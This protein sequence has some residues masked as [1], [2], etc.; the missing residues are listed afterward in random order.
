RRQRVG[1]RARGHRDGAPDDG[2]GHVTSPSAP[3]HRGRELALRV[4]YQADVLNETRTVALAQI[5]EE[6]NPADPDDLAALRDA[7]PA[8]EE[9]PASPLDEPLAEFVARLVRT[10]DEHAEE[11]DAKITELAEHWAIARM[12]AVD[13]NVLRLGAAEILYCPDVPV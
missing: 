12:A 10:V 11:I 5:V 2:V 8:G 1:Q 13:R 4:L 9:P 7:L 6:P 3:R